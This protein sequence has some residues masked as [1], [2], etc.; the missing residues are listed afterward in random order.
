MKIYTKTGDDGTTGT[1]GGDRISKTSPRIECLGEID[2]LNAAIGMARS[3]ADNANLDRSLQRIQ[4]ELFDLGA[5]VACPAESSYF[6]PSVSEVHIVRL[7]SEMDSTEL[8]PLR[9][10]ILPGGTSYAAAIHLART[11]CR[12]TERALLASRE[13]L[14]LRPET[15]RYLNRL[16]DWLFVM[17]RLANNLA[18]CEDVKWKVSP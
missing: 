18:G 6:K 14:K 16:S 17:A 7:E 10:F 4:R 12:R 3:F 15:C 11:I 9:D 2:E 5:E 13:S 8:P 1:F